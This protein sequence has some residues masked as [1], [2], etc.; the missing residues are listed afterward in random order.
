MFA[1]LK[2]SLKDLV[3]G[4]ESGSPEIIQIRSGQLFLVSSGTKNPR[5]L[6]FRD[7]EAVIRKT[8]TP[9]NYQIVVTRKFEEGEAELEQ[10]DTTSVFDVEQSAL[11][12][13]E[14]AFQAASR[15]EADESGSSVHLTAISWVDPAFNGLPNDPRA[16][17]YEFAID[18]A[19]TADAMASEFV[20]CIYRSMWERKHKASV[21]HDMSDEDIEEEFAAFEDAE[22][23]VAGPAT[24]VKS[25]SKV[26]GD[27]S[28][29]KVPGFTTPARAQPQ[30]SLA[31]HQASPSPS[32]PHVPLGTM[33]ASFSGDLHFWSGDRATFVAH[34]SD[35]QVSILALGDFAYHQVISLPSGIPLLSQDLP[36]GVF[37]SNAY[38]SYIWNFNLPGGAIQSYSLN[39]KKEVD[40]QEFRGLY[41]D[42]EYERKNRESIK[43][44]IAKPEDRAW[45][46]DTYAVDTEMPDAEPYVP[47][48]DDEEEERV[49]LEREERESTMDE[50]EEQVQDSEDED[51]KEANREAAA[52]M[53]K[54]DV[55]AKGNTHLAVGF[56]SDRS[57]VVRGNRI[58]VFAHTPENGLKF[59]STI[60]GV[61]TVTDGREFAPSKI[62]LH[63]GD[64]SMLLMRDGDDKHVYRMDVE[65]GEVVEDW[66]VHE[67]IGVD[68]VAPEERYAQLRDGK[69]VVGLNHNSVFKLDPRLAGDKIVMGEDN[70][71]YRP[72]SSK[73]QFTSVAT[74]E[75]G[76]LAVGSSKGN[77]RLFDSVGKR[78][79]TELPGLGDPILGIDVSSDG[80]W[81]LATCK[82]YILLVNTAIKGANGA[83]GFTKSMGQSKP[84]PRRLQLKP[85]H[86]AYMGSSVVFTPAR[87][88][89]GEGAEKMIVTSTGEYVV[90][91]NFRKVKAGGKGADEY[92]I[93]K[94]GK[95][96][97]SDN[98]RYNMPRDIVVATAD[99]VTLV[100][101]DQLQTPQKVLQQ[102]PR[103]SI[104]GRNIRGGGVVNSPY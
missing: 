73:P 11:I 90:S 5:K 32:P 102:T 65:R 13:E 86:V 89:T 1:A 48:A 28:P 25:P 46:H 66:Q 61:R 74:D 29:V 51:T 69:L 7:A 67:D 36:H 101:K 87:F 4:R 103:K 26:S 6:L 59:V 50:D 77:I 16:P 14:F 18:H 58:G 43:K 21:P 35:C 3:W 55:F 52:A 82:D 2:T 22:G 31:S 76:H 62:M 70:K 47:D 100:T 94:Y 71:G 85:E 92:V 19:Q 23:S 64:R 40:F 99:N 15:D 72:Y 30:V 63:E 8:S 79:K 34:T 38:S 68:M 27:I 12:C 9:F 88:D 91:W 78:A 17:R 54:D 41:A 53:G 57:F 20:N 75:R 93:K 104:G 44:S 42:C 45:L 24:P 83:T 80:E 60:T 10:E 49:R 97:V 98:F 39:F 37:F 84:V 56:K 33:L 95:V 96:V 81:V